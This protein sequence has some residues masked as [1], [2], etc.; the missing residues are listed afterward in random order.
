MGESA[1]RPRSL[2]CDM[3]RHE[4]CAVDDCGCICHRVDE[5]PRGQHGPTADYGRDGR[6]V[7]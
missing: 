5:L 2:P 3:D 4:Q 6:F 7:L 1:Y